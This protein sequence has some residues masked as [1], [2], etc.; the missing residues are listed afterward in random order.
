MLTTV[1]AVILTLRTVDAALS[2]FFQFLMCVFAIATIVY[3]I[4]GT[5]EQSKFR[6][7][8]K[9]CNDK[10]WK[11]HT[12]EMKKDHEEFR[13]NLSDKEPWQE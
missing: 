1:V 6:K 2:V 7:L 11:E 13:R 4:R 9:E 10:F 12:D 5:I 8:V 3:I